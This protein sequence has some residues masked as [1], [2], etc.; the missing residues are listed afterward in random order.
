MRQE[1]RAIPFMKELFEMYLRSIESK[2]SGA[3]KACVNGTGT[4]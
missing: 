3:N 4:E 1:I 2:S